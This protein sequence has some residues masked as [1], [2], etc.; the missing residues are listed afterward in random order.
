MVYIGSKVSVCYG[1]GVASSWSTSVHINRVKY[2]TLWPNRENTSGDVKARRRTTQNESR[3]PPV[4][5]L[6]CG[7]TTCS[8]K[9]NHRSE[10]WR[11]LGLSATDSRQAAF[12]A[13]SKLASTCTV[14]ASYMRRPDV[15]VCFALQPTNKYQVKLLYLLLYHK[16][17]HFYVFL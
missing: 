4:W 6:G 14:V 8:W 12:I 2:R 7:L 15:H 5:R 13:S 9:N 11:E 17:I 3:S 1:G 16:N 10:K